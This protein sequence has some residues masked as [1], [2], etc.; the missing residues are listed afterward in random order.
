MN[1][2][3]NMDTKPGTDSATGEKIAGWAI[4]LIIAYLFWNR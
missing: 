2:I 1:T 4:L 3:E